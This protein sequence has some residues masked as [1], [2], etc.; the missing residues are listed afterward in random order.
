MFKFLH[1]ADIHLDSPLRGLIQYE[2]MP[3]D[4]IRMASRHAFDKLV[5]LAIA[6]KVQF[7]LIAGDLYDG[8]WK[9]NSVGLF[10]AS[11]M[12]RLREA[13]IH[14]YLIKG[15]HDAVSVVTKSL[16][17]PENTHF[18][19]SHKAHSLEVPGVDAVIH[20][21]SFRTR[22]VDENLAAGYPPR[23]ASRFNIGMLHTSLTGF[24]GHEPYAPCSVDD[25]RS[26]GYE[27]WALGHV[28][29]AQEILRG[30]PWIVFPGNIQGRNI[31]ETGAKGCRI[32]TV[33]DA[34]R[35]ASCEFHPLDLFRWMQVEID[36]SGAE[37]M[38]V[39]EQAVDRALRAVDT[40]G[41]I[42]YIVRLVLKGGTPLASHFV[43]ATDWRDSLRSL[44]SD[45]GAE[46][47][48]L[49]KIEVRCSAPRQAGSMDGPL[50]EVAASLRDLSSGETKELFA[51]LL[52]K[53]PDDMKEQVHAMLDPTQPRYAELLGEVEALLSG[54]LSGQ[55]VTIAD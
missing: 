8:D 22:H 19:E 14:V 18:F 47:I 24:E 48:W 50:A 53:L 17:L 3:V 55:A 11:R 20:G 41:D 13:G 35:V 38:D 45:I 21:H 43:S 32:V 27:Y 9:D 36:V 46:R 7:V 5:R 15:N 1:A 31:R 23:D 37:K 44:T 29:N 42:N 51:P 33:D 12:G 39:V 52:Q 4:E 49:E 16:R 25:L 2:P 6:E 10:F 34:H 30:D 54:R 40:T 26:K 28:H